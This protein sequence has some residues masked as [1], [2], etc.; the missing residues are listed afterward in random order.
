MSS[1]PH[2]KSK[3]TMAKLLGLSTLPPRPPAHSPVTA[4]PPSSADASIA[5]VIVTHFNRDFSHPFRSF[6]AFGSRRAMDSG[7]MHRVTPSAGMSTQSCPLGFCGRPP[8]GSLGGF[9][10]RG[11]WAHLS[12]NP[13]IHRR[14]LVPRA[15]VADIETRLFIN[16]EF[17]NAIGGKT[18]DTV[19]VRTSDSTYVHL[20]LVRLEF[21]TIW[22]VNQPFRNNICG[23]L[24]PSARIRLHTHH[25]RRCAATQPST[26]EVICAVH[27][28]EAADVERAVAGEIISL[29]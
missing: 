29:S 14:L 6:E 19:D 3:T 7:H 1:P 20:H 21:E 25:H 9:V 18:F 27:E 24:T 2:K 5:I 16:G 17:V 4:A 8:A 10:Y 13:P 28:A 12:R 26:E 11:V 22:A 15:D 23:S